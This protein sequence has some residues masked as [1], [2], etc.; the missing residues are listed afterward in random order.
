VPAHS[1]GDPRAQLFLRDPLRSQNYTN[2]YSSPGGRNWEKYWVDQSRFPESE[3]NPRLLWPDNG[4][5]N[6][7]DRGGSPTGYDQNPDTFTRA[8]VTN[9]HVMRRN[10]SGSFTN[11]VELGNVYD[12]FQWGDS[13]ALP[14]GVND[15]PGMWT[16]LTT[17]ATP[18]ARFGG[19][20]TLRVGRWE[21]SRFTNNGSRSSQLLDLFAVGPTN[22]AGH[23]V[24][25]IPGRINLNTASTNALRA[26]AAGVFHSSD[27]ELL[28]N[29]TNFVI[30]TNAVSAFVTGVTARRSQRP[31][32]TPSELAMAATNSSWPAGA[33][34]GNS[35]LA[36]VR[37]W[38][39]GAA[40]EWFAKVFPLSTVRSRNF[41]VHVVGQALQT[42][43]LSSVL[44]SV[45]STFQIHVEPVRNTN[46]GTISNC[47]A[48]VLQA[49]TL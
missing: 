12:P 41:A 44:S 31:F 36:T 47:I 27:P 46:N 45:N 10:D 14:A 17:S 22:G 48:R 9:N 16:N 35:N 25:R 33:V 13:A 11:V 30:P 21:F 18:D 40:E 1:G 38:N 3:V 6:T 23:V 26:L 43:N 19:R 24:S 20:N 39:D 5:T 29:G 32:F 7:A 15:Q 8:P 42:N 49:W 4:H 2:R 34:F 37:G 28:P